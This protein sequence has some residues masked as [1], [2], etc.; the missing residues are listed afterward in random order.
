MV[1]RPDEP[2]DSFEQLLTTLGVRDLR[3]VELLKEVEELHAATEHRATIEQAKGIIMSTT[4]C[5]PEAAFALLVAQSQ[6]ENRK[7]R[8]ITAELTDDQ[9]RLAAAPDA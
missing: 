4:Q 8:E 5:S 2:R 7:L 9:H 3:I 1:D 6:A